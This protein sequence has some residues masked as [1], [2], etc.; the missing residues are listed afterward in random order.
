MIPESLSSHGALD[1]EKLIQ[2]LLNGWLYPLIET[3]AARNK[4]WSSDDL[5][6]YFVIEERLKIV[7]EPVD[8]LSFERA[9]TLAKMVL[10]LGGSMRD[11]IYAALALFKLRRYKMNSHTLETLM[12]KAGRE[13]KTTSLSN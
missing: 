12:Q 10:F 2:R 3:T 7:F 11:Y 13:R 9:T 4:E 8:R 6:A 5:E 1:L